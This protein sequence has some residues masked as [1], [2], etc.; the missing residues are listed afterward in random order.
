MLC[1]NKNFLFFFL[2]IREFLLFVGGIQGK[3]VEARYRDGVEFSSKCVYL[4]VGR[5]VVRSVVFP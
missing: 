5:D 1:K 2:W 3:E 4:Y